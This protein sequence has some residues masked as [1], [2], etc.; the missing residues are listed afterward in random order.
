MEKYRLNRYI[1]H[2]GLCSRRKADEYIEQGLVKVN[3][4]VVTDFNLYM[5][6]EDTLEISKEELKKE[7]YVYI[8]LNK[9]NGYV[10]TS[11][12][13]FNRPCV[14]DII[15]ETKRIYPVGR[16]DMYSEGML[17]LTNDGDFTKKITH[18]STHVSK[19]YEVTINKEISLKD[20]NSLR[21]GVDIGGY[22]TK[23]A[24]VVV[25][26]IK[27]IINITISEGKNRQIRKMLNNLDYQIL[28]L[29]RISIGGLKLGNLKTKEYRYL[30]KE[31]LE[32][33][34]K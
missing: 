20:L 31:E 13:Q 33:I 27:K 34:F 21:N 4:K 11:K 18:P 12:E 19:T 8:I 29:K 14:L 30:K 16:L 23:P 2:S 15:S 10:T 9:P 6:E 1:A 25:S 32:E 5:T 3:G 22:V 17:L 7:E 28:K 24:N 26:D